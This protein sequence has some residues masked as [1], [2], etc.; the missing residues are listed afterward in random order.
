MAQTGSD[1]PSGS[2]PAS[3]ATLVLFMSTHYIA[4]AWPTTREL[5]DDLLEG[6]TCLVPA[7]IGRLADDAAKVR[8]L[9]TEFADLQARVT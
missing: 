5:L 9:D 2:A 7:I 8:T 1:F 6:T 4:V 3:V